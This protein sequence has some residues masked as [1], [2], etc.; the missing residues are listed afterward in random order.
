MF[1][2]W[3][4]V[5]KKQLVNKLGLHTITRKL[6]VT[7]FLIVSYFQ[8]P[9]QQSNFYT[10]STSLPYVC[11]ISWI[12]ELY[13]VQLWTYLCVES[14]VYTGY[15]LEISLPPPPSWRSFLTQKYKMLF[16]FRG[17]GGSKGETKVIYPH[18]L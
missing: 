2:N 17:R 13:I 6:K 11:Y 7:I 10:N 18:I 14:G 4:Q 1:K 15:F 3:F 8:F 9:H 16:F 5:N 12:V